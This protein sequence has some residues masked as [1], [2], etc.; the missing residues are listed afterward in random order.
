MRCL[1]DMFENILGQIQKA[2]ENPKLSTFINHKKMP[3]SQSSHNYPYIFIANFKDQISRTLKGVW[4]E[5]G[6]G[7]V[8]FFLAF[9]STPFLQP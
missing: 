3:G 6:C 8:T 9:F 5:M 7:M 1:L 2:I 4:G